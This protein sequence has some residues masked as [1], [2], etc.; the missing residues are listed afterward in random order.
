MDKKKSLVLVDA[1]SQI[2]RA[3]YAIRMLTNSRGEPVNA[4][5]VFTKFMLQLEKSHPSVYGAMLFDCGKVP[6]RLALNPE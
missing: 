3:F 1:Y 5:F 6:F 4:A 2:Y